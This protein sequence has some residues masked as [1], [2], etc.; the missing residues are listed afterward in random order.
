MNT[1]VKEWTVE[2][3]SIDEARLILVIPDTKAE[4][5]PEAGTVLDVEIKKYRKKRSLKANAYMWK[6]CDEI[7]K[8]IHDEKDRVYQRA[9]KAVGVFDG[10]SIRKSAVPRFR[11][12]WEANGLGFF[13]DE[14][15]IS[16]QMAYVNA[17]YGS[18]IYNTEQMARLIDWL[19]LEAEGLGIDVI[20]PAEK[21]LMMQEW[22]EEYENVQKATV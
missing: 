18:H 3:E 8:A 16:T 11:R 9:V 22:Q 12:I 7:A 21:S 20:T 15:A 6:V 17:Y 10:I 2:P 4:V 1:V 13:I 14:G 19:T 5:L